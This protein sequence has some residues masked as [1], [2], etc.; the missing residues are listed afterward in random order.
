[1]MLTRII[2]MFLL[3]E[4][5]LEWNF[6]IK[7]GG[8]EPFQPFRFNQLL[9]LAQQKKQRYEYESI[10]QKVKNHKLRNV[11]S[12]MAGKAG[13]KTNPNKKSTYRMNRLRRF[14]RN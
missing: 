9:A 11:F 2:L 14:H 13:A 5:K 12:K 6:Q 4:A 10:V 1:M 3:V 8:Q 7:R